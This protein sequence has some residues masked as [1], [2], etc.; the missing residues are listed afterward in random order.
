MYVCMYVCTYVSMNSILPTYTCIY[1][2]TTT[3]GD[4]QITLQ[5]NPIMNIISGILIKATGLKRMDITGL[6]GMRVCVCVC[7]C[8]CNFMYDHKLL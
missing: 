4:I 6:S 1:I 2:Q 8:V 3:N 5:Y 7:V